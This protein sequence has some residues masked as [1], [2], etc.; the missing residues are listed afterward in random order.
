LLQR[1]GILLYIYFKTQHHLNPSVENQPQLSPPP[2]HPI[3]IMSSTDDDQLI[4]LGR[5]IKLPSGKVLACKPP[6]KKSKSSHGSSSR[7]LHGGEAETHEPE[8]PPHPLARI[9]EKNW[10]ENKRK[11]RGI[12]FLTK[13]A[14]KRFHEL[15]KSPL[16]PSR[17]MHLDT[18]KML[19]ID[20]AV[21]QLT[22]AIRE[23]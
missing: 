8:P 17:F 16:A 20:K 11:D 4:V 6:P 18:M 2:Q 10:P 14:E 9:D 13:E 3:S 22:N 7:N 19:G 12:K 15:V 23:L 21:Q 1:A 5:T